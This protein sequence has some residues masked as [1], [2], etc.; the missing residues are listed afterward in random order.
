MSK[1][2]SVAGLFVVAFVFAAMSA[3]SVAAADQWNVNGSPLSGSASLALTAKADSL[4]L[5]ETGAGASTPIKID[6]KGP[7]L[8]EGGTITA[9]DKDSATSLIFDGCKSQE[10]TNCTIQEAI[11]TEAGISSLIELNSAKDVR[12]LF[13]PAS[14]KTFATFV[15]GGTNCSIAGEKPING[16][17]TEGAPTGTEERTLQVL[18]GLGTTEN[19]IPEH[20]LEIA[21]EAYFLLGKVLL[22]LASKSKWSF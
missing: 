1:V 2:K 13:K 17:V 18:E 16:S 4:L 12:V 5:L 7:V 22:E 14:G 9:P 11:E 21:K 20:T 10:P 8:I 19:N 3:A 6:C 15:Y